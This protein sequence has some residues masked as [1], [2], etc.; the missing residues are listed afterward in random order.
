MRWKAFR[1]EEDEVAVDIAW[2]LILALLALVILFGL[3][4]WV[5]LVE[6]VDRVLLHVVDV[7]LPAQI[8]LHWANVY[9][10]AV[11]IPLTKHQ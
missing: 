1:N 3:L 11:L 2:L 7:E 6:I 8:Q 5:Y 10:S 4:N 9:F